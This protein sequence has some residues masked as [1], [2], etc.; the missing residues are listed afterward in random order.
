MYIHNGVLQIWMEIDKLEAEAKATAA[1]HVANMLQRPD[2]LEKVDQYKRRVARKKGSVEAMLKTAMQSQLDGVRTGLSQLQTSLHD[3]KDIRNALEQVEDAYTSVA[4]LSRE[5]E[6]LRTESVKHTQYAAAVDNVKHIV[7][8]PEN[9]ERAR[10]AIDDGNLLL[11]HKV[12]GDLEF[13]RN[14]LLY[15]LHKQQVDSPTDRNFIKQYFADVDTLSDELGKQLWMVVARTLAYVRKEP[16]TLVTALRI[17]ERE[18]MKDE[19]YLQ[20]EHQSAFAAPGRPKRWRHRCFAVLEEVIATKLEANQMDNRGDHK[21]WLV[22]HLEVTRQLLLEDLQVVKTL[23]EPCFPPHYDIVNRLVKL[24]HDCLC[25]RLG[26]LV[27]DELDGNEIVTLLNWAN[28]YAGA[29]LMRHPTL[30]L[31][32][33]TLGPLLEPAVV[34]ALAD[35]YVA[36]LGANIDDWR[37]NTLRAETKDWNRDAEPEADAQ[38][39]FQTPMPI[40]LFQMIE[41]HL[42]VVAEIGEEMVARVLALCIE[43]VTEFA[44]MY[45]EAVEPYKRHHDDG[46]RSAPV[47]STNP[48]LQQPQQPEQTT[49]YYIQYIIAIVNNCDAFCELALKLGR[50]YATPPPGGASDGIA[51]LVES[52]EATLAACSRHLEDE[53][54]LDVDTH[55][56][57]LMSKQWLSAVDAI[58]TICVTVEDYS[59]DFVHLKPRRLRS[60]MR[61]IERRLVIEYLKAAMQ[62]KIAL[63]SYEERRHAADK[64]A[65]EADQIERLFERLAA[66]GDEGER[67]PCD[68]LRQV[69]ELL[70]LRDTSMLSL[71]IHGL[72]KNYPDISVDHM[73]AVLSL[74]GDTGKSEVRQMVADLMPIVEPTASP[75]TIFSDVPSPQS[76]LDKLKNVTSDSSV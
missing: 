50:R 56:Q 72:V 3:M 22:R 49:P 48:F 19:F 27:R 4:H 61:A 59:T 28:A 73:V 11:A 24:Y 44:R 6:E 37:A 9:V 33:A 67:S 57:Q 15:E 55:V 58:D 66:G 5:L 42:Q 34:T 20:R 13:S 12:I 16:T 43:K 25:T 60:V 7:N 69:S 51:R 18:E 74:R 75:R 17:V 76:L 65:R 30:M 31:D 53:V 45:R 70:A 52:F 14:G 40:I 29:E 54:F 47:D 63:K 62:R 10:A 36:T 21:M 2:Q 32:P 64:M 41:Q 8:V 35:K 38:G 26:D 46:R 39:Y 68:A 71:E 23:C 1:K